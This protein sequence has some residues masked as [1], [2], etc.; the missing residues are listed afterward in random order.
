[1]MRSLITDPMS[2]W[3]ACIVVGT[4]LGAAIN[5]YEERRATADPAS[6]GIAAAVGHDDRRAARSHPGL[7]S[8]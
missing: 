1:M 7:D 4:V 2:W 6:P 8:E 5:R 3:P